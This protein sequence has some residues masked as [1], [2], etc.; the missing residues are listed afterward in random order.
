[1]NIYIYFFLSFN[2]VHY[3]KEA[4]MKNGTRAN[5]LQDLF[6]HLTQNGRV[7]EKDETGLIL[8]FKTE[9]GS[10]AVHLANIIRIYAKKIDT[11][12]FIAHPRD[13]TIVEIE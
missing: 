6:N 7:G 13:Y 12:F 1:M 3:R 2:F 10:D 9:G 8:T 11:T 5:Q 4:S